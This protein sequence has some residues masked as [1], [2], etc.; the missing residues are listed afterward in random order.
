MLIPKFGARGQRIDRSKSELLSLALKLDRRLSRAARYPAAPWPALRLPRVWAGF[1]PLRARDLQGKGPEFEEACCLT[2][3]S[4]KSVFRRAARSLYGLTL[5]PVEWISGQPER[6]T[7][8]FAEVRPSL[9]R[10]VFRVEKIPTGLIGF[11]GANAF[12]FYES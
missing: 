1:H 4:P 2:S 5:Y 10:Q 12:D 9:R 3:E 7:A 11:Q 8:M 6:A